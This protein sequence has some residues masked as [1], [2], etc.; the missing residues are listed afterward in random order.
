MRRRA[1]PSKRRALPQAPPP[2]CGER[3]ERSE[4][5]GAP[6]SPDRPV[7]PHPR[8]RRDLSLKG[9]G[10]ALHTCNCSRFMSRTFRMTKNPSGGLFPP[11]VSL[12]AMHALS[13]GDVLLAGREG[14]REACRHR[15]CNLRVGS[16]QEGQPGGPDHAARSRSS[17]RSRPT[18][19]AP[20]SSISMCAT[21][22]RRPRRIPSA[23]RRSRRVSRSIVRA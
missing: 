4:G 17:R 18:R 1:F 19:P 11:P 23:S 13:G 16:A 6:P 5:E 9:E 21:T 14:A 8:L 15:R 2:P 7:T 22:T 20:L 12:V 10:K 3:S